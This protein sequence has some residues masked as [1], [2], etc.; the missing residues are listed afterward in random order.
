MSDLAD[1]LFAELA[2]PAAAARASQAI[3][4]YTRE[5]MYRWEHI[6]LRFYLF[7][8]PDP[9]AIPR[10]QAELDRVGHIDL[11]SAGEPCVL[12]GRPPV[13]MEIADGSGPPQLP[14]TDR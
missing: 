1:R 8:A 14:G 11:D 3:T 10:L 13:L 12:S 7:D 2:D 4:D 5:K 6:P 9:T